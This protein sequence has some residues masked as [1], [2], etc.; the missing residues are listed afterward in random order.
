MLEELESHT[1]I[2]FIVVTLVVV[3]LVLA[4]YYF[5]EIMAGRVPTMSQLRWTRIFLIFAAIIAVILWIMMIVAFFRHRHT[6]DDSYHESHTDYTTDP[7]YQQQSF[8]YHDG[9][10]PVA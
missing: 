1:I 5:T 3:A 2:V 7:G 4:I 8:Y 6:E 9:G 10:Y